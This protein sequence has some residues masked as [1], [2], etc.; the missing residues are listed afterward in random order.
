MKSFNIDVL[1]K[2]CTFHSFLWSDVN[3][4]LSTQG[5]YH[6]MVPCAG[7]VCLKLLQVGHGK[8]FECYL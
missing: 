2:G 5:K 8:Y 1:C 7:V 3:S 6:G 4:F